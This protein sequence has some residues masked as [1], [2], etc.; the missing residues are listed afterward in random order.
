MLFGIGLILEAEAGADSEPPEIFFNK[1]FYGPMENLV[2][3]IRD[4][5]QNQDS[6]VDKIYIYIII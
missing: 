2:V 5:N 1:K 3:T 4:E 6:L